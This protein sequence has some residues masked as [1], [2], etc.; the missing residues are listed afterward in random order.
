MAAVVSD[1][2]PVRALEF[3]GELWILERLFGEVIIPPTVALEL[4]EPTD[5]LRIVE[6]ADSPFIR[7]QATADAARVSELM[8]QK[9]D[10]GESEAIALALEIEA[11]PILIDESRGRRIATSNGLTVVG[12]LGIL[13]AAKRKGLIDSVRDRIDQL[14]R[15]LEFFVGEQLRLHV[16]K[17]AGE[18]D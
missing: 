16:L 15:D 2:S 9:L 8:R 13:L 17:E 3:I 6:Y 12:T 4:L 11:S 14:R 5:P 1:T 7:V 18:S 10:R